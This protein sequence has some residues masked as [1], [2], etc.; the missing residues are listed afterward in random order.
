MDWDPRRAP[1]PPASPTPEPDALAN[2]VTGQPE[3]NGA[4]DGE[5]HTRAPAELPLAQ[6]GTATQPLQDGALVYW[7][8]PIVLER[9]ASADPPPAQVGAA[10]EPPQDGV[11][12]YWLRPIVLAV[13]VL[14]LLGLTLWDER[15]VPSRPARPTVLTATPLASSPSAEIDP[16]LTDTMLRLQAALLRRDARALANLAHPDGLIVAAFGGSLPDNG[17]HVGDPPRFAAEILAGSQLAV[18]GWRYD[19]RGRVILLTDGWPRR[20]LRLSV[21]STLEL[22]SLTA[23]GLAP[24]SGTWYW[25]WLLPDAAGVLAQQAR[26]QVWQPWPVP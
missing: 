16:G 24:Q 6:V 14:V 15:R 26:T 20:P 8:R 10:A 19:G 18:L 25:R 2:G 23:L 7:L 22:T 21:N 5:L 17:Y 1:L 4:L 9:L 11:L 12:R 3:R 13:I